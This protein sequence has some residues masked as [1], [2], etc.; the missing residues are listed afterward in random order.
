MHDSRQAFV[1]FVLAQYI[2]VG[3]EEL[4]MQKLAPLLS[5]CYHGSISDAK[6]DLGQPE[7]MRELFTGFQKYLYEQV[8]PKTVHPVV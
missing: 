7:E 4:D 5:L 1:E 6:L 8:P 3:V 2:K